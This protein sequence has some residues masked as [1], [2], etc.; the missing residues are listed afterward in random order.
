MSKKKRILFLITG[1]ILIVGSLLVL[2]YAV[3]PLPDGTLQNT[4]PATYFV[5]P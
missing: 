5:S 3:W 1:L 2:C 4:V